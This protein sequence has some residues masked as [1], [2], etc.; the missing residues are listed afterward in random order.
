MKRIL[1]A[2]LLTVGGPLNAQ[3]LH[4]ES[5][6]QSRWCI[7]QGGQMEYRLPDRTRVDCLTDTHAVEFDFGKKWAEAIGQSL[8]YSL[9]TGKRAGVALILESDRDYKYWIRL[10]TTIDQYSLPID[11]WIIR[12]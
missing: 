9:S 4:Y 5:W 12:P 8:Y 10:N 7:A 2:V 1:L 3:N 6:Y 11:A